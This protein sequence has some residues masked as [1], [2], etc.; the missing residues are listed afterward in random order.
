M[1][2]IGLVSSCPCPRAQFV[3]FFI[4]TRQ[5]KNGLNN[6]GFILLSFIKCHLPNNHSSEIQLGE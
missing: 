1:I 3:S 6:I 2:Q 4:P 5:F